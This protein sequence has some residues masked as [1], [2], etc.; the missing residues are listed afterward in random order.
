MAKGK[1]TDAEL[2]ILSVLWERG[3][4]TVRQVCEALNETRTVGYTT[5]PKLLQIMTGKGLVERNDA[6]RAHVYEA[7]AP[8]EETQRQLLGDLM[9]QAF[10]G[11]ASQLV[12]Q[13]LSSRRATPQEIEQ[14]RE[15]LDAME[16]EEP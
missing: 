6:E 8:R 2:R 13:A 14:I 10:A 3:P 16:E 1:P 11:S 15:L 12:M 4:S 7:R 5:A 9:E